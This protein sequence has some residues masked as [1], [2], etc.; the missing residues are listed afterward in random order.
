MTVSAVAA[1]SRRPV[2]VSLV[3]GLPLA[4]AVAL[5]A[6]FLLGP[7]LYCIYSAFT[8]MSL[9]GASGS[10]FVGFDT[11][12]AAKGGVFCLIPANFILGHKRY[13]LKIV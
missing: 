4:P 10:Q 7:I 5:L 12:I 8:N 13:R 9:T 3:R 1:G 2:A 11:H 6:V